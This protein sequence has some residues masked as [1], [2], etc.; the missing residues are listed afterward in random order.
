MRGGV[1][2]EASPCCP[3]PVFGRFVILAYI[4]GGTFVYIWLISMF[5]RW[6]RARYRRHGTAAGQAR[7]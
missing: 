3:S 5:V 6:A 4:V 2:A 7:E 1:L